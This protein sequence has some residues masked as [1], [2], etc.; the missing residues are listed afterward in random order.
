[1]S[2][3]VYPSASLNSHLAA[4]FNTRAVVNISN[5]FSLQFCKCVRVSPLP[6]QNSRLKFQ[7][8]IPTSIQVQVSCENFA[9]FS[10]A[11][12][13]ARER[14]FS[15]VYKRSLAGCESSLLQRHYTNT[16]PQQ[17]YFVFTRKLCHAKCF[18]FFLFLCFQ[19]LL[20]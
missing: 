10:E 3:N 11:F 1:M 17:M 13:S 20:M 8:C 6:T 18:Y 19:F 15:F 16:S 5:T 4:V 7:S 12:V 2:E 9:K 14:E